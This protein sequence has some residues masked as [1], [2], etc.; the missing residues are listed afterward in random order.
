MRPDRPTSLIVVA[1][2]FIASGLIGLALPAFAILRGTG[3]SSFSYVALV[4]L[5]IGLGLFGRDPYW[6]R[7]AVAASWLRIVIMCVPLA[8]VLGSPM[9]SV[10]LF[11]KPLAQIP[12]A[13]VLA[14]VLA[15]LTMAVWALRVLRNP[16]VRALYA[17]PEPKMHSAARASQGS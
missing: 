5:A 6:R 9:G 11:G 1:Y 16:S 7:A 4:D 14:F 12:R 17:S 15:D 8:Y 10:S 13:L 2:L 3:G